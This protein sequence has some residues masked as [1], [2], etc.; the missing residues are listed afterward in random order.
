MKKWIPIIT[1]L[2][3]S[4]SFADAPLKCPDVNIIK[5]VGLSHNLAQDNNGNW[6][7]G[8]TSQHYG[9]PQKW[10]FVIGNIFAPDKQKAILEANEALATLSF[11]SGPMQAPSQKW[12]CLY[13]NDEGFP[14]G[15]LTPPINEIK[16]FY[17]IM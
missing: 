13:D 5:Q 12:L 15:A 9:T 3:A 8:R 6:Y 2:L 11:K 10:T 14:S 1:I 4:T 16:L 17:A 7:A